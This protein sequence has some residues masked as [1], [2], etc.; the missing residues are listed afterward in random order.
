MSTEELITI[1]NSEFPN[2][3]YTGNSGDKRPFVITYRSKT[4][5]VHIILDNN[6]TDSI[7][8]FSFLSSVGLCERIGLG[9]DLYVLKPPVYDIVLDLL[10]R[11]NETVS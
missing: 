7:I 10:R 11:T 5:A 1:L 4:P 9:P 6:D 8:Q 2:R 3:I